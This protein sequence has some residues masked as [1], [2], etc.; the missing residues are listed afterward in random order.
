MSRK[1]REKA[2]KQKM[3]K[4]GLPQGSSVY[5]GIERQET[6]SISLISFNEARLESFNNITVE[7]LN[8][9]SPDQIHWINIDGIHDVAT[10]HELCT[11][12]GI[13]ALTEE[14]LLNSLSRP[15]C[16]IFEDYIYSGIKMLK[17]EKEDVLIE[18]EQVS[19]ILKNNVVITFQET[20]G[21]VFDPIRDRLHRPE[22]RLRRKK[23][24]Y[25]FLA[26]HDIIV[27]NYIS[28]IDLVDEVNQQI[29]NNILNSPEQSILHQIQALKTDLIYLKKFVFPVRE[30]INKIM[31][32]DSNHLC[33][34]NVKYFN[35]LYDHLIYVTENIDMQREIVVSHR[36][37]YM[38]YI[39]NK[40]NGVMQVLTIVTTI[41]IPLSFI[42]GV[43]GMNFQHMPE[44]TWL[45]GY[46]YV[47]A[48]MAIVA[49]A[50]LIYFRKK[51]WI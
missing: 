12:Y 33:E 50:M 49:F 32:S 43:Y 24:D 27:D 30:S 41:F 3:T 39:S 5:I 16:E 40:M 31:R 14:D 6:V 22:S 37:L 8:E 13:H 26:I 35:D 17:N 51:K 23:A 2:K 36:E 11:L 46:Y 21:D 42:A 20:K 9:L 44:L 7:K 18:D 29:E 10:V 1:N 25:L 15:K 19:I 34:D 47:L 28:I 48:L 38:S 45:N 4:V